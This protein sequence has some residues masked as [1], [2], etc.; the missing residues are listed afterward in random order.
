[1]LWAFICAALLIAT[2]FLLEY[3]LPPGSGRLGTEG[4]GVGPGALRKAAP[5]W[6]M[7]PEQTE[8]HAQ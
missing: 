5:L 2:G 8:Q 1:M 6:G 3:M 7:L 4:F